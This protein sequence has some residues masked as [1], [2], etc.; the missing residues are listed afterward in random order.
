MITSIGNMLQDVKENMNVVG[1]KRRKY[2]YIYIYVSNES[3]RYGNYNIGD[4]KIHWIEL[5]V[6]LT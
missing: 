4:K 5:T 3:S 2:I 1:R 6:D